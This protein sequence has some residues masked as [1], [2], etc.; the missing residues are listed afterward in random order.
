MQLSDFLHVLEI[1]AWPVVAIAAILVVRP[2]LSSILSGAKIKLTVAGASIETT[3][4]ELKQIFEEQY[5]EVLLPEHIAYLS[6]LLRE[7]PR[8]YPGGVKESDERI[9]LRPLRNAGLILTVPRSTF[10]SG[11]RVVEISGLGRLYLRAREGTPKS[12]A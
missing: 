1:L 7:G 5:A 10:L 12:G 11:A 3:L 8:Q 2:Y 4:P 9:F 6:A